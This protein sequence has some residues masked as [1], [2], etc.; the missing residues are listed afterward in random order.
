MTVNRFKVYFILCIAILLAQSCAYF[1]NTFDQNRLSQEAIVYKK[2]SKKLFCSKESSLELVNSSNNSQKAFEKLLEQ[3]ASRTSLKSIDKIVLWS[4]AQMNLRPDLAS[5]TSK[6]QIFVNINGNYRYFHYYSKSPD[7]FPYLAGLEDLLKRFKSKHSLYQLASYIDQYYPNIFL[8]SA[9]FEKFL[10]E[11]KAE[12][13]AN[14]VLKKRYMRADETL[15]EN[16]KIYKQSLR[17]LVSM[18]RAQS[19]GKKSSPISFEV[20][21]SLFS[22]DSPIS[23]LTANCNYDMKLYSNSVY[24][25]HRDFIKSH[26]FGMRFRGASFLAASGQRLDDIKPIAN[27]IFFKGNS[28]TRSAAFCAF[29][30]PKSPK[31]SLWMVSSES[32]DPGQHIYHLMEYGLDKLQSA[33][34]LSGLISHS[35][36]LFLED[37]T[38]L[39]FESSRSSNE[40][41]DRL[42][43]LNL[44]IY[45][46][47][48]LG[49]VWGM[50]EQSSKGESASSGFVIDDRGDG[51]ISCSK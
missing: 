12:L 13:A 44:P 42:L 5:P 29:D 11:R 18:Y 21:N 2:E 27:T 30:F 17:N 51:K 28:L 48:K 16:E 33:S 4:L 31:S 45:N 43:K 24:L 22:Y 26:L 19:R 38:R 25:I 23:S 47:R 3:L 36:H 10:Q 8:V 32:R 35:R 14:P 1:V 6:L 40:Q 34:D 15:R 37:P 46:A 50:L 9:N 7:S 49:N 39:I 41:L 20:T